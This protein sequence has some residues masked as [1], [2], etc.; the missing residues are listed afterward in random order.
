VQDAA[1]GSLFWSHDGP[2][3]GPV[4]GQHSRKPCQGTPTAVLL[5]VQGAVVNFAQLHTIYCCQKPSTLR[6][7]SGCDENMLA[8]ALLGVQGVVEGTLTVG[9]AVLFITVMNQ[10]YVPLTY[11]G[12]YYRQVRACACACACVCACLCVCAHVCVRV[13]V[14]M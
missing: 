14:C 8:A 9:D 12:S 3:I 10:L 11:F 4:M 6:P 5:G 1:G 7:L 2:F 13:R